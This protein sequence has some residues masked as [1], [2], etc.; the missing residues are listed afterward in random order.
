MSAKYCK[1]HT[2]H[3]IMREMS[4]STVMIGEREHIKYAQGTLMYSD[5]LALGYMWYENTKK[6]KMNLS[7]RRHHCFPVSHHTVLPDP[8]HLW[9]AIA[10]QNRTSIFFLIFDIIK[11]I[12]F[13][14]FLWTILSEM[15]TSEWS[16][17]I[18]SSR[19]DPPLNI[20]PH[21]LSAAWQ[22]SQRLITKLRGLRF[23]EK[24]WNVRE[25]DWMIQKGSGKL[26]YQVRPN[27]EK[28]L[29]PQE[30]L[31]FFQFML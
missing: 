22:R 24:C 29:L 1:C 14:A 13:R 20:N 5:E 16:A 6:R 26:C 12:R 28:V 25:E 2:V 11:K 3:R 18:H 27:G 23:T 30:L 21:L 4:H 19:P 15:T 9:W 7:R 10:V 8:N 31:R 17:Q